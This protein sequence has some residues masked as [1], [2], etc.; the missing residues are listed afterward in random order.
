MKKK[1]LKE[2]KEVAAM[3][4]KTYSPSRIRVTGAEI[5]KYN[6]DKKDEKGNPVQ[7][8]KIYMMDGGVRNNHMRGLKKA[9]Q[10]EGMKGVEKYVKQMAEMAAEAKLTTHEQKVE[11][12]KIIESLQQRQQAMIPIGL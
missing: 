2:F 11:S 9:Y 1:L 4:P 12:K 8:D 7:P 5:L 10:R 6:P 3:F